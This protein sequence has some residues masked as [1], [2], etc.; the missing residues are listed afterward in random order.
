MT[1]DDDMDGQ[2]RE[3]LRQV[4]RIDVRTRRLATDTLTGRFHSA[5]RGHGMDFEEVREYVP[6]DE[7]RSIDWNVTA[8]AGHPF[9]KKYREERELTLWL[10][11]DVSASGD[12]GS[13]TRTKRQIG[14]EI[15]GLLALCA[16]RN[17]DKVGLVLFSDRIEAV[18]R[19][20]KDRTHV[21]RLVREVLSCRPRRRGTDVAAALDFLGRVARRR[22]MICLLSDFQGTADPPAALTRLKQALGRLQR[23]HD[24]VAMFLHDPRERELPD[25]GLVVLEDAETG[26]L[27]ELDTGSLRVRQRYTLGEAARRE[28]L[29]RTLRRARIDELSLDVA[30]PYVPALVQFFKSRPGRRH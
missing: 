9:V 27:V 20:R 6:G 8:R 23:R 30:Q 2:L 26:E 3:I 21:L 14:A 22:A 29:Q 19:P 24:V 4:R 18:L 12:F 25:V 7:V 1:P 28:A 16:R 13:G 11:V 15:A 10:A 17:N 5:F